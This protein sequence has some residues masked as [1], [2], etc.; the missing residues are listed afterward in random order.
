MEKTIGIK[1]LITK[2][3]LIK[4]IKELAKNKLFKNE[5]QLQFDLAWEIKKEL[6]RNK[7]NDWTVEFEYLSATKPKCNDEKQ[8]NI[9]TD[10]IILNKLTGEY[11]PIELK[12]KTRISYDLQGIQV[13]K[14]QGA[15][16]LGR[17]DFLWDLQRI[18]ILKNR[19]RE[20]LVNAYLQKMLNGFALILTNDSAYW[21][22]TIKKL[23]KKGQ[24][25]LYRSFCI[26][27][28]QIIK[29][30][31]KLNWK[32]G[33][34]CVNGTWRE[35]VCPLCFDSDKSCHWEDC[36]NNET[37]IEFKCLALEI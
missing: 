16:D 29:A 36:K 27:E 12:Y 7:L 20:Y 22:M 15:R 34:S 35:K 31:E 30:N 10:L 24:N 19:E 1:D 26:G 9:Y 13:L 25:P 6:D 14:N 5:Q 4:I 23:D 8:K 11:I 28:G 18:Q 21:E 33:E 2:E 3:N 17:F 37:N 32:S